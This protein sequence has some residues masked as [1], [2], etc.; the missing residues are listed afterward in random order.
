[1]QKSVRQWEKMQ[2]NGRQGC[3]KLGLEVFKIE[4]L[5]DWKNVGS[6]FAGFDLFFQ[7]WNKARIRSIQDLYRLE[8]KVGG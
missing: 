7:D 5:P 2:N 4:N 6:S 3:I 8:F 1:M